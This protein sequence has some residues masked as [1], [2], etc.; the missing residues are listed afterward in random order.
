ML[1]L[2][3][4]LVLKIPLIATF[5]QKYH[6][7]EVTETFSEIYFNLINIWHFLS[8]LTSNAI[9]TFEKIL[10][11]SQIEKHQSFSKCF[12]YTARI[13][14]ITSLSAEGKG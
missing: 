8:I 4:V 9:F 14:V 12:Q 11:N 3:L 7:L 1:F 10:V 13:F 5:D 2:I 6:F